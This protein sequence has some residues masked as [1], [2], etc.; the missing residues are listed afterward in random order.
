MRDVHPSHAPAPPLPYD[1]IT[2]EAFAPIIPP[3]GSGKCGWWKKV[4]ITSLVILV[5]GIWVK[6]ANS[7][8]N[9]CPT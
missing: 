8:P 1:P 6:G 5:I 2:Y 3:D 7:G 9:E 4:L